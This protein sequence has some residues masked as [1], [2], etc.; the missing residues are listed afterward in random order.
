M[1]A[2]LGV[3]CATT[4]L[5]AGPVSA[6][7]STT[8]SAHLSP[9]AAVH[10]GASTTVRG[11]V[12]TSG[13]PA[14]GVTVQLETDRFPFGSFHSGAQ[15]QTDAHG[16]YAF[17]VTPTLN[18]RFRVST[19]GGSSAPVKAVLVTHQG[20]FGYKAPSNVI[21][22]HVKIHYPPS[23]H[24]AGHR[25][26]WYLALN[27][28]RTERYKTS[29]TIGKPFKPGWSRISARLHTGLPA[30]TPYRFNIRYLIRDRPHDGLGLAA[31]RSTLKGDRF[32]LGRASCQ[33]PSRF[34]IPAWS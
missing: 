19:P 33:R 10:L 6:A 26:Y 23:V 12:L 1:A 28:S 34:R 14:P 25:V 16:R 8:V 7:G 24:E 5:A 27:G 9:K 15:R 13:S 17:T 22:V 2:L 30:G 4:A 20:S 21:S 18:T 32:P 11:Q 29:T 3:A 31:C